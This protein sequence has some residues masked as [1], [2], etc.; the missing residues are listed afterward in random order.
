MIIKSIAF[1]ALRN[2]GFNMSHMVVVHSKVNWASQGPN[3]VYS[4]LNFNQKA[5][6]NLSPQHRN[7]F[8][9]NC[10]FRLERN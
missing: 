9:F 2:R 6:Y 8:E 1:S 7:M 5:L 4:G 10:P 3:T